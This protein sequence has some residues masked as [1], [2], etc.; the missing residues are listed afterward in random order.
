MG[1]E[2]TKYKAEEAILN[3]EEGAIKFFLGQVKSK[4]QHYTEIC[5]EKIAERISKE[6]ELKIQQRSLTHQ[7]ET[8]TSKNQSV[9]LKYDTL[10]QEVDNHLSTFDLQCK[11]QLNELDR[12]QLAAEGRLQAEWNEKI[13]IVRNRYEQKLKES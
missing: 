4:R 11:K 2:D 3:Q 6:G 9:K 7:V 13:D 5:I 12:Q 10:T 1:E 8:L